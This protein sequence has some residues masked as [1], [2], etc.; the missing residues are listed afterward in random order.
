MTTHRRTTLANLARLGLLATV[1]L[2]SA[3][4]TS[5]CGGSS[6]STAD[7]AHVTFTSSDGSEASLAQLSGTPLVVNMWATWCPPCVKEMPA[8]DE[9]AA[10][11]S[12]V[13]VIGINVGDTSEAAAAFAGDLGVHYDQYTDPDGKL[14]AALS[15]TGLPATAFI[16]ADGTIVEVH[17]GA[18][19]AAQLQDAISRHFPDPDGGTP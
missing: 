5:S 6:S 9:V 17:Q 12:G 16:A 15:V 18:Y 8:F 1:V 14:S 7:A 2:A 19:T 3:V 10:A 13:K 11:T 4:F